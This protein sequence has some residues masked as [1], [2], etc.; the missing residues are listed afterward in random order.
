VYT[1]Q[2]TLGCRPGEATLA[3]FAPFFRVGAEP[4]AAGSDWA[5]CASSTTR[6][7]P[8]VLYRPFTARILEIRRLTVLR[9]LPN[10]PGHK[11]RPA[12]PGGKPALDCS[13]CP[14][15]LRLAAAV[16]A[17]GRLAA[18]LLVVP[19]VLVAADDQPV[20]VTVL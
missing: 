16:V 12:P 5:N 17:A 4:G 9:A 8:H 3:P 6:T 13:P 15:L 7:I 19:E 1:K 2:I 20:F 14:Y 11:K 10:L 18:L